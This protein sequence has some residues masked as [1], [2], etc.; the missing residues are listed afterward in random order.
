MNLSVGIVGLPNVGKSTLFNALL[1]KQAAFVANYPFATI[2]PNVGVVPVPDIRL[3]KLAEITK[4][5]EKMPVLPPIKPATVNFVDIAGLVKGASEGAGLGNKFLSHIREVSI[6]AHVVRAFEDADIIREGS[7]DPKSDYETI[8]M[9]LMLADL[10][11]VKQAQG[12]ARKFQ[13]QSEKDAIDKLYKGLDSGKPARE[14]ELTDEEREF[15]NTFFLLSQKPELIVLNVSE[16]SLKE[17]DKIIQN[18]AELLK[19]NKEKFVVVSAKIEAEL[20]ELSEEEQKAYLA[21]LGLPTSGLERLIKKAY[22]TLGLISFL[23]CGE[24][25]VR[26]WTIRLGDTSLMA[27]GTIHTD[28]MKNFIKV[29][30]VGFEDFVSLNGW[31]KAREQGRARSE[32]RDYIMQDGDVVEFK[33]G[34]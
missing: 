22:E 1:K 16:Q 31:R 17:A 26:A 10:Q 11:T 24:K 23:T 28:F 14:I 15:A 12:R 29:E 7:V 25:E 5:E 4:E 9:E 6:I 19:V 21:D 27:S 2:E 30:V 33:I 8:N 3:Q 32:G 20:A 18:Y 34:S 13:K